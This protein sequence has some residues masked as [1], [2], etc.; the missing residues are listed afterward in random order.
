MIPKF[1]SSKLQLCS[2]INTSFMGLLQLS[3]QKLTIPWNLSSLLNCQEQKDSNTNQ[4]QTK[5]IYAFSENQ[6]RHNSRKNYCS[7]IHTENLTWR[8]EISKNLSQILFH[9]ITFLIFVFVIIIQNS[10]SEFKTYMLTFSYQK[11]VKSRLI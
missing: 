11:K 10:R 9:N 7:N 8:H 6:H 2:Q 4:R 3:H 1:W 5:I